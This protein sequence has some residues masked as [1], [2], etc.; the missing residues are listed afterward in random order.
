LHRSYRKL[1]ATG[2]W[3]RERITPTGAVLFWA[4]VATGSFTDVGQTMAH[5]LFALLACVLAGAALW[6]VRPHPRLALQRTLPRHASVGAP[7]PCRLRLK[8]LGRRTVRASEFWEGLPDPRPTLLQFASLAEPGE[9][10]RNA[11]DRRYRFYRWR[12]ILHRNTRARPRPLPLP[13][14]P[15]RAEIELTA[16][17]V[18]L[19]RGRLT[20]QGA[21]IAR[22][23]PFGLLRRFGRI[24]DQAD[25]VVVY[26]RR[27]RLPPFPLPGRSRRLHTGGVA[28]AGSVGD[29]EEFVSVR[30]YRPGDP[31]RRIHWAGWARTQR[32][33]VKEFQEE[34]FVRHALALDTVG[35]GPAVDAFEDAVSLAASFACTVDRHDSLLDLMFVGD[36]AHVFTGGRGL[37]HA[38]QMLEILASVELC[39]E[40]DP[41]TLQELVVRNASQLSGCILILLDWD[42]ARRHLVES[43]RSLG[44]PVL[45]WVV[46][47]AAPPASPP[48]P[49]DV[50]WLQAGQV[51]TDLARFP[52]GANASPG[53]A[54]TDPEKEEAERRHKRD[55]RSRQAG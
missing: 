37:A 53:A 46:H 36:R 25:S 9:E 16:E 29:S 40:G 38:T 33:I 32:P 14:L 6:L 15:P 35:R 11:F 34:Y 7:F 21:R 8:N 27:F 51:E 20:L 26:P 5:P 3:F 10:S 49:H 31:L 44:L 55:R 24:A 54:A 13:A 12:W 41:A 50:R 22:S 30:E 4:T 48:L 52:P 23:D 17:I 1:E 19:R 47:H 39:P 42:A 18:P 43:L 2:Q 28:F 45:A